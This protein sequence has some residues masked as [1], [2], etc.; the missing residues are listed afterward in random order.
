MNDFKRHFRIKESTKDEKAY[1]NNKNRVEMI[2]SPKESAID[3]ERVKGS[4]T[5]KPGGLLLL[6]LV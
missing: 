4:F 6:M 3:S 2:L 5:G 1:L